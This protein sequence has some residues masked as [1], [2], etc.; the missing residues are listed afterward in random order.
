MK[1]LLFMLIFISCILIGYYCG[2]SKYKNRIDD[3]P[4]AIDGDEIPGIAGI[5]AKPDTALVYYYNDSLHI[6]YLK[7]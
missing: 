4:I 6:K 7:P 2:Y 5:K 3:I 1:S